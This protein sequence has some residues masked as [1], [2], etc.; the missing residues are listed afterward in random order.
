MLAM[1]H[2]HL[3]TRNWNMVLQCNITIVVA[4]VPI[5]EDLLLLQKNLQSSSPSPPDTIRG[6]YF[7]AALPPN[8]NVAGPVMNTLL[9]VS[10]FHSMNKS[11]PGNV[12]L[13]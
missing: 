10:L 6:V 1:I 12:T 2:H 13:T 3:S 11:P 9:S 8:A 4:I 7:K 5:D